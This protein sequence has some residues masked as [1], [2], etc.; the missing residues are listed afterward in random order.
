MTEAQGGPR[1]YSLGTS[2]H[3]TERLVSQG[4]AI[5]DLTR[6][7]FAGAGIAPGMTVLDLGSGAGD[8]SLAARTLVGE[9]GRVIGV[10]SSPTS[11]ARARQR[12]QEAGLSNVRF[13]EA[14]LTQDLALD[15]DLDA[16]VGRLVLM[17]LPNRRE[18]LESLLPRLRPG[19]IVA[20][21]EVDVDSG[22]VIDPPS[23]LWQRLQD[24][25]LRA[26]VANGTE[27]LM[28]STL[29]QLLQ[30]CG[31]VSI[32]GRGPLITQTNDPQSIKNRL[33]ILRS[34]LPIMRQY[35]VAPPQ[36]L[37]RFDEYAEAIVREAGERGSTIVS[38][39]AYNLWARKP[40]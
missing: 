28:G 32:D 26:L 40:R 22:G 23:D 37:D 30:D 39:T 38:P 14:D 24:W 36:E 35:E 13:I 16:I 6:Q 17:Y 9:S 31:L 29:R 2:E 21:M 12:V 4:V 27:V 3:E 25:S 1:Q 33:P 10:D 15:L 7:F 5:D 34:T 8:S 11:L 18:L 20:L 19:G